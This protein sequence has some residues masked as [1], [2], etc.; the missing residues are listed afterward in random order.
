MSIPD[1]LKPMAAVSARE[2]SDL[3]CNGIDAAR[4]AQ[5]RQI[6]YIFD[7]FVFTSENV[8]H[9]R[10]AIDELTRRN[11]CS[12][13]LFNIRQILE[14]LHH[15]PWHGKASGL[16]FDWFKQ[17]LCDRAYDLAQVQMYALVD[18]GTGGDYSARFHS[19]LTSRVCAHFG[20]AFRVYVHADTGLVEATIAWGYATTRH[21]PADVIQV[22]TTEQLP[23]WKEQMRQYAREQ[24][25]TM[26]QVF[27]TREC[28]L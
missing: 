13:V 10:G 5:A 8:A 11:K 28:V 27:A 17:P 25:F 23:V 18:N 1:R 21:A 22:R 16:L 4:A 14:E 26:N 2:F 9:A 6:E 19:S 20:P 7:E 24:G 3:I 12:A 15:L